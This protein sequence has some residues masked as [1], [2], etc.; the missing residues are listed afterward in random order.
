MSATTT[1]VAFKSSDELHQATDGFIQR[2]NNGASRPEPQVIE[3]IM[4]LFIAESLNAFLITPTEQAN[5]SSGLRKIIGLTADTINKA[6]SVVIRSTVKKLNI[7]QNK[8]T[9]EYMDTVRIQLDDDGTHNWY[10]AFPLSEKMATEGR[11]ALHLVLEGKED[12]ARA[13][14]IA[15]FHELTDLAMHWYFEQPM[16]LLRFGPIMRKVADVGVATTR[17]ALH[18][19]IDRIIPKLHG[20]E[21]QVSVRY[22][23]SLMRDHSA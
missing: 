3:S 5:L 1:Y 14:V 4:R 15:Y 10:V 11:N 19:T 12:E 7:E 9:A 8:A 16:A 17:K 18:S 6:T 2:M 21:F 23:L 13:D 22:S 20:E